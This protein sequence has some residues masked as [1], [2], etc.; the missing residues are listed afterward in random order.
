MYLSVSV[1]L[2]KISVSVTL[3]AVSGVATGEFV[4]TKINPKFAVEVATCCNV[5]AVVCVIAGAVMSV[6]TTIVAASVVATTI[7]VAN[8]EAF[9]VS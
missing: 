1:T 8:V 2:D 9:V 6:V 4:A 7:G 5:D 3:I